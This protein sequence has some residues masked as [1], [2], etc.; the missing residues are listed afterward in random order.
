MLSGYPSGFYAWAKEPLS[1]R[2]LEDARRT[3][4]VKKAWKDSGK[5]YG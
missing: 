4:L 3:G 1:H 5:V 2:A